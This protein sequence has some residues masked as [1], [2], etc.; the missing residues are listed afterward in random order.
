MGGLK[1]LNKHN[2]PVVRLSLLPL[3][4]WVYLLCFGFFA[5]PFVEIP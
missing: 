4:S 2:T 5:C 3:Y 1:A